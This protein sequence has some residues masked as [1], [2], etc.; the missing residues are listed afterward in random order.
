[1]GVKDIVII[2]AGLTG[3]RAAQSLSEKARVTV[4]EKNDRP[5]GLVQTKEIDGFKHDHTGH[6]LHFKEKAKKNFVRKLVAPEKLLEIQRKSYIYTDRRYIPYPFQSHINYLPENIRRRCLVEFLK[7]R[8]EED[9]SPYSSFYDWMMRE[10]GRGIVEEFMLPYNRKMWTVHPR[11]LTTEWMGRFVPKPAPEEI[12]GGIVS[13]GKSGEGYNAV[14]YYPEGGIGLL[15]DKL[16][17]EI[18]NIIYNAKVEKV[19]TEKKEVIAG[20]KKYSYDRLINTV[21]LKE[22]AGEILSPAGKEFSEAA[23][24]LS[25]TFLLYFSIGW[26]GDTGKE[27]PRRAHWVYFP[28][29]EFSFYRVGFPSTLGAGL[30]P[31]GTSSAY[32]EVSFSPENAPS[33]KNILN[34]KNDL[35]DK[36]VEAGIIPGREAV[37]HALPEIIKTAYVIYDKN[38]NKSRSAIIDALAR[39]DIYTGG[40]YGGWEYSSMEDALKWGEDLAEL[41]LK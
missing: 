11:E 4:L 10:Y 6:F 35:L 22:F 18:D 30:A 14:F 34:I 29:D 5:G 31:K 26:D 2:G 40:R 25:H 39:R 3:L 16:A 21:S 17:G 27:L 1:M 20:G 24:K 33:E 23:E 13:Q 15:A 28:G 12:I 8:Q 37:I 7:T 19:N 38:H 41:C 32:A 36:L 9:D